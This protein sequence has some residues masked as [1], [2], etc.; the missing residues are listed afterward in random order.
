[1]KTPF[2]KKSKYSIDRWMFGKA[3]K[4][5]YIVYILL[6]IIFLIIG[7]LLQQGG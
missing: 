6:F 1:M 4:K 7:I 2:E 5:H 3:R